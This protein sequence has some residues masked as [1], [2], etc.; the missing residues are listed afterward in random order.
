MNL[1]IKTEVQA[2]C[3]TVRLPNLE[4]NGTLHEMYIKV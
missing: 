4:A 3:G 1:I 2:S